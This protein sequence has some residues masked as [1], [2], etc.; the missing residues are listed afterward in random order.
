VENGE[1]RMTQDNH[2]VGGALPPELLLDLLEAARAA[3]PPEERYRE[4]GALAWKITRLRQ[5]RERLG[6]ECVSLEVYLKR[7]A[8]TLAIELGPVL[9][10]F[11]IERLS[12]DA[13]IE[14]LCR[15]G[16]ELGI[17]ASDL[18]A[19]LACAVADEKEMIMPVAALS[20]DP[21]DST[22]ASR[23]ASLLDGMPWDTEARTRL[24]RIRR[25]ILHEYDEHGS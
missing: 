8:D 6:F 25:E 1:I 19:Y 17:A 5:E 21:D 7:L 22:F 4:A 20:E 12:P 10:W 13:P 2:N 23:C 18:W 15:L 11:G 14:S 24:N 16:Q 9:E 3:I